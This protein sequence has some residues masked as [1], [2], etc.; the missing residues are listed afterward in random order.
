MECILL[1]ICQL[2][3]EFL[4]FLLYCGRE[5]ILYV[6]LSALMTFC[7]MLSRSSFIPY[8]GDLGLHSVLYRLYYYQK[9][10]V[11][12]WQNTINDKI[13]INEYHIIRVSCLNWKFL[14]SNHLICYQF[15]L[16]KVRRNLPQLFCICIFRLIYERLVINHDSSYSLQGLY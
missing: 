2:S 6:F 4:D 8:V 15:S 7:H 11:L 16:G 9:G 12:T 13:Q 14:H 10:L 5:D 3:G 1:E